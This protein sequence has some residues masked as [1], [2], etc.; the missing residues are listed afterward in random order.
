MPEV[1]P[2]PEDQPEPATKEEGVVGDVPDAGPQASIFPLPRPLDDIARLT[3]PPTPWARPMEKIAQLTASEVSAVSADQ[4][5]IYP[6]ARPFGPGRQFAKIDHAPSRV[7]AQDNTLPPARIS[8]PMTRP[9]AP[10]AGPDRFGDF[11][12]AAFSR[13]PMPV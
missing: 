6:L 12:L 11:F 7:L 10:L 3:A 13:L 5:A 4:L 8:G 2:A 9:V 1:A